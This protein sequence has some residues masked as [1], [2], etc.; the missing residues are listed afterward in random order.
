[1]YPDKK[2]GFGSTTWG[3]L[4]LKRFVS[5]K[6]VYL[7]QHFISSLSRNPTG[8]SILDSELELPLWDGCVVLLK[9]SEPNIF[10]SDLNVNE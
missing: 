10:V 8:L 7:G 3:K 5:L 9:R 6:L 1:M 4:A 2:A